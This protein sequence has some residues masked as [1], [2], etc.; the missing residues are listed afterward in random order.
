MRC[1]FIIL[2]L[3]LALPLPQ[4]AQAGAWVR[5]KGE[6][7]LSFSL[8]IDAEDGADPFFGVYGEYGIGRGRTL[9]LELRDDGTGDGKAFVFLRLPVS[10]EDRKL[11]FAYELGIGV[12]QGEA[13]L[14]P[15]FSLGHGLDLGRSKGWVN[16]D[17]RALLYEDYDD[18]L[19]EGELTFGWKPS[20]KLKL[21]LQLQAGAPQSGDAYA[22]IAP[23]I[24]IRQ[25]KSRHITFGVTAGIVE[26]EGGELNLG[27]WQKF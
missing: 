15:G 6:G 8:D 16:L 18:A 19:F 1:I 21:M 2:A 9:G 4:G 17:A 5:E 24:A 22:K 26:V 25:G 11:K 10:G 20:D 23:S 7:F 3:I 27:L 12:N 13:A 14:R